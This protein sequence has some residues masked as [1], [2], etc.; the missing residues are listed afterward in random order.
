MEVLI[1]EGLHVPV[2]PLVEDVGRPGAVSPL[3]KG[4]IGLKVGISGASTVT[5][6]VT[7]ELHCVPSGVKV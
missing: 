1:T 5:S 3:Q 7:G 4:P 6:I 2:I